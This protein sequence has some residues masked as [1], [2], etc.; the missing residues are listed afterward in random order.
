M[1]YF[2]VL[3]LIVLGLTLHAQ[4]L[5]VTT[6]T[7]NGVTKTDSLWYTH[8]EYVNH[9]FGNLDFTEVTSKF[10]IDRAPGIF[11]ATAYDGLN[12]NDSTI[13]STGA[14]MNVYANFFYAALDTN[15]SYAPRHP[16]LLRA[17]VAGNWADNQIPL[18]LIN[19]GYH[20]IRSDA[21][22]LGL[23]TTSAD[24][25]VLYDNP[26]RTISPYQKHRLFVASPFV[27][28]GKYSSNG[29]VVFRVFPNGMLVTDTIGGQIQVDFGDGL[30]Y[31]NVSANTLKTVQYS[32]SGTKTIKVRQGAL[33]SISQFN[34]VREEVFYNMQ[35]FPSSPET[36]RAANRLGGAGTI[37]EREVGSGC[38][39]TF[40]KPII[41]IEGFNIQ[42]EATSSQLLEGLNS[43][44]FVNK[45]HNLGYDFVTVRFT[46]N[47]ASIF[48]N[49][50]ALR[51]VIQAVNAAKVGTNKL[52]VIGMS[53]GGLIAKY[54]LKDMEDNSIVH[55]VGN[56]FSFDS[57][58]QGAYVPLGLQHL[59]SDASRALGQFRDDPTVNALVSKLNSD[60]GRQLLQQHLSD[61]TINGRNAFA[62]NYAAKGYPVQCKNYGIANGRAD[63]V[64]LGYPDTAPLI[65]FKAEV[66][67]GVRVLNHKQEL[68]ST[69][70]N[71]A[72]I[73][74]LLNRGFATTIFS[75][76]P[77]YKVVS[78]VKFD[79]EMSHETLPGSTAPFI[80]E[81]LSNL[82]QSFSSQGDVWSA[83]L[84]RS[85][86][87]FVPT[88]SALDLNNQ[89]YGAN[90]F[91]F[92]QNP[93][94]NLA[95][96]PNPLS[97]TP[98]DAITYATTN[99]THIEMNNRIANFIFEKIYGTALP[100]GCG[101]I[102]SFTPEFTGL[103]TICHS[104]GPTTITIPNMPSGVKI[105]WNMPAGVTLVSGGGTNSISVLTPGDGVYD[106]GY[107]TVTWPGCTS[108]NYNFVIAYGRPTTIAGPVPLCKTGGTYTIPY[109][110]SDATVVWQ[111]T[112]GAATLTSSNNTQAQL[113]FASQG[114]PTK[115]T[116]TITS[117]TCG[118]IVLESPEL[119]AGDLPYNFVDT[120]LFTDSR[121]GGPFVLC[122]NTE[123]N[124]FFN[125][126]SYELDQAPAY[127]L[128]MKVFFVSPATGIQL[129]ETYTTSNIS[130]TY[131][132]PDILPVGSFDYWV[133]LTGGPCGLRAFE[134]AEGGVQV[135]DCGMS[136]M[137]SIYPNP[138]S[139]ELRI[140]YEDLDQSGFTAKTSTNKKE[141]DFSVR[142][143][144]RKGIL[145]KEGKTSAL[146]KEVL[147]QVSDLPNDTYFLHIKEGTKTTTKQVIIQH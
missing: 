84:G 25:T 37:V 120:Q 48:D 36:A 72:T 105:N 30:G 51:E 107:V 23:I 146:K 61:V 106:G 130:G 115:L 4:T 102:C 11:S 52:N 125:A 17:S 88:A 86:S 78:R 20:S 33:E 116:A 9:V 50:L 12:S 101:N 133:E 103:T 67:F 31:V 97:K 18:M 81:Y 41:L 26:G 27:N 21:G 85:V 143:L 34:F 29:D 57:P 136:K 40:D 138:A 62:S 87:T 22:T 123:D 65:D 109:L 75:G 19:H 126:F 90:G 99:E 82:F 96:D 43:D 140:G 128:T 13:R 98:F 56:Y 74:Y 118:T 94:Y 93:Y 110:P 5:R 68:F 54:C 95:N 73:S 117:A 134:N 10:L 131:R 92:S 44:N 32:S 91:Y 49:A 112:G 77:V 47:T 42:G 63:G 53:M 113:S 129:I 71:N 28:N 58:H 8:Q 14:A 137:V 3:G 70:V 144:N 80:G 16:K 100:T 127:P 64:G 76:E 141:I 69:S 15:A 39:N 121:F 89:N 60:A 124:G 55:D 135:F 145:V 142:L 132:L 46:N 35:P 7:I 59:L 139:S 108:S 114:L 122:S 38:D 83:N 6:S 1:K 147:L 79:G 104:S 24:Q 2:F 45:L 66:Y 119:S 111:V